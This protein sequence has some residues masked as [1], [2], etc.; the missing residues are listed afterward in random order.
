MIYS[1][2]RFIHIQKVESGI[3]GLALSKRLYLNLSL[4]FYTENSKLEHLF[5]TPLVQT[6]ANIVTLYEFTIK[7][8][9]HLKFSLISRRG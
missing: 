4:S 2:L 1:T 8:H 9:K 6:P 7:I 3:T 5:R